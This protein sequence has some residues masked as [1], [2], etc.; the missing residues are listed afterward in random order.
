MSPFKVG[1]NKP[2]YTFGGIAQLD[3]QLLKASKISFEGELAFFAVDA[4]QRGTGIGRELYEHFLRY[5]KRENLKNFYLYTDC[6]CNVGFYEHQG[7]ERL[8]ER[9]YSLLPYVDEAMEFYIYGYK[10][11]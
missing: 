2:M 4:G 9:K 1:E 7:L 11:A 6:T 5:L 3:S 8:G 10:G